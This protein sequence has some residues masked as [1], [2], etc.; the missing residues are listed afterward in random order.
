MWSMMRCIQ[1]YAVY[2]AVAA[3]LVSLV[4]IALSQAGCS[5]D[6]RGV[7]R[8]QV[9]TSQTAEDLTVDFGNG[10]SL[11]CVLIRPGSFQMGAQR[12]VGGP[13]TN[14]PHEVELTRAFYM[15]MYE[16]T[17]EQ[18]TSVMGRNPSLF[19][20]GSLPVT[21]VYWKDAVGFCQRLSELTGRRVR[22]PTEAEWEYACRAGSMTRFYYGD[23]PE[24]AAFHEYAWFY[25]NADIEPH[26]VGQKK[27]N[28]W[29]LYDMHGNVE[30]WCQDWFSMYRADRQVDPTGPAEGR[31]HV[32]RGGRSS[33]SAEWCASATREC[34]P[35]RHRHFLIGF[36]VVIESQ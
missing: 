17:Q 2:G 22:L 35:P 12:D 16:V 28:A 36:R 14:P 4:T 5:K 19:K 30:E 23:D 13:A 33:M 15:G 10:A 18:Y 8:S 11:K 34:Y 26:P 25:E 6:T 1:R 7:D 3:L 21:D 27:P 32:C 24:A 29:G 20:G 31:Y 9:S